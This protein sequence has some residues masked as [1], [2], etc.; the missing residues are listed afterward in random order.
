MNLNLTEAAATEVKKFMSDE[1]LPENGGQKI[2]RFEDFRGRIGQASAVLSEVGLDGKLLERH[3]AWLQAAMPVSQTLWVSGH[4]CQQG[5]F[6]Q[7]D[8][9]GGFIEIHPGRGIDAV[10][11]PA[12]RSAVQIP[13]EDLGP[14]KTARGL[15]RQ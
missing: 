11:Q 7:V 9:A 5:C 1:E 12:V 14:A 4:G 10:G 15:E 13:L 3:G 2:Q 6:C 8:L